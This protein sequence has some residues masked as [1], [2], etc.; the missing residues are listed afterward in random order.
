METVLAAQRKAVLAESPV[1]A[2]VRI[3]RLERA[4]ALLVTHRD[5]LADA[6]AEDF[7][8]RPRLMSQFSDIAPSVKALAFAKK[9]VRRWMRP[10]RRRLEFPLGLLG[11]KAWIEYQPKGVVGLI[12]PWNFPVNLTFAPLA[13]ILAA[14][15]RVMIK[16]SEITPATSDT[17]ARLIREYFDETEITVI[18]GGP[19][20]GQ[21]FSALPFDH[22]LFTGATAIGRHVMRAAADNLT[23]VTLELGGK[24]PVIVSRS[25][26]LAETARRV[27]IGKMMNAGQI[28]LAPDY[29]LVPEEAVAPAVEAL[30]AAATAFYPTVKANPD[31]TPIVNAR[32]KARLLAHIEDATRKGARIT[33]VNP[34]GED[35]T[36]D[37]NST[38]LPLHILRDVDDGMTVMQEEIFGPL[39]PIV[40]YRAIED[41]IAYV[42]ARPRPLGLY[43]F[44][45]DRE[46]ERRV[47][48][49]TVSGGVTLG[50]VLWHVAHEDLPFGGIGPSG[51]GVY[52]GREGFR[53]FSHAKSIYRQSRINI[54]RLIG[55]EPPYGERLRRIVE[56]Q[57]RKS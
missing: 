31:Y 2:A 11:A 16:P 43:Y 44:G 36:A 10:E 18:T 21:V 22:L 26:D 28:C 55:A 14:G 38:V 3:D 25:A 17:M 42:N 15:N 51:M 32:H 46:E 12:S 40:S 57:I 19:E 39:L 45:R 4:R 30:E 23:P 5:S 9:H 24:S 54:G 52:H 29:M 27:I 48:D 8:G 47:L 33:V 6:M 7:R 34:A 37:E 50:D 41:A 1:S 56:L 53:T 49:R 13:G 35:F 20:V